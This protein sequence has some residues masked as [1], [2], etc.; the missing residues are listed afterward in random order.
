MTGATTSLVLM[1]LTAVFLLTLPVPAD[2][3]IVKFVNSGFRDQAIGKFPPEKL[4]LFPSLSDLVVIEGQSD[5][6]ALTALNGVQFVERDSVLTLPTVNLSAPFTRSPRQRRRLTSAT[7]SGWNPGLD[8]LDQRSLPLSQSF[9][10]SL[11][12]WFAIDGRQW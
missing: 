5:E 11:D 9:T 7:R 1:R 3:F 8:R 2:K 4:Q 12:G 10:Y 6:I